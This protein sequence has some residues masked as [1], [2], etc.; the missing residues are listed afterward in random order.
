MT[1]PQTS[2]L[3]RQSWRIL[4]LAAVLLLTATVT[5]IGLISAGFFDPKPVGE[6]TAE[7]PLQPQSIPAG[8]QSLNWLDYPLTADDFSL[9]LTAAY[10]SGDLDVGYGLAL[11]SEDAALVV[12]VSPL[13]YAAITHF[14]PLPSQTNS[15][16]G[17]LDTMIANG[18]PVNAAKQPGTPLLEWQPW[19]HVNTDQEPNEIWVDKRGETI[20]VRITREILWTGN[21]S[22]SA[23]QVGLWS[24]SSN[25]AGTVDF[26]TLAIF[27]E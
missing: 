10:E 27:S 1:D 9:R 26:E 14:E 19:P 22:I 15:N 4:G 5:A 3:P 16:L 2:P 17:E 13:G 23:S 24:G 8:T 12:A 18:P 11:G 7:L 6:L 20:T 21:V 25:E